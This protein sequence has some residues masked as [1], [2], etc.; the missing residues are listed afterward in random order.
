MDGLELIFCSRD[1]RIGLKRNEDVM[2]VNNLIAEVMFTV[3]VFQPGTGYNEFFDSSTI[4][5]YYEEICSRE[6]IARVS[7]IIGK[8]ENGDAEVVY[9]FLNGIRRRM[10]VDL[11][12]TTSVI[13]NTDNPWKSRRF[14][15]ENVESNALYN[16]YDTI[17]TSKPHDHDNN[18]GIPKPDGEGDQED[19][20]NLKHAEKIELYDH[21]DDI[22]IYES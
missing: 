8:A 11:E 21:H 18:D 4:R 14:S 9:S 12:A 16:C 1:I 10:S 6:I 19:N 20:S 22:D 5:T 15:I 7:L 3:R 17:E 13:Y 2:C